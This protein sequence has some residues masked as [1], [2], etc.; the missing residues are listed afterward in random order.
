[1]DL[2]MDR[3][4]FISYSSADEQA[5]NEIC[6]ALESRGLGCWIAARDIPK[7]STWDNE[8]MQLLRDCGAV[9]LVLSERA[10]DSIQVAKEIERADHYEKPILPVRIEP[11]EP[12]GALELH[13]GRRQWTDAWDR[14]VGEVAEELASQLREVLR[15]SDAG[16]GPVLDNL[17]LVDR[18]A[19]RTQL[20]RMAD[21]VIRQ[22]RGCVVALEGPAGVGK[23]RLLEWS[24][25]ELIEPMG[26][27]V[28]WGKHSVFR[29]PWEGLRQIL[30][31]LLEV[32][33][34][35]PEMLRE[36]LVGRQSEWGGVEEEEA[37]VLVQALSPRGG[38]AGEGADAQ[39]ERVLECLM[40]A[41]C[42][43]A[44]R[45]PLAL[46][47]EDIH[48]ADE[49]TLRFI[50][51]AAASLDRAPRP[52]WIAATFR[53]EEVATDES[54]KDALEQLSN[55]TGRTF[56]RICLECLD[57][58]NAQALV[59]EILPG[60]SRVAEELASYGA[61]SPLFIREIVQHLYTQNLI[62]FEANS[63]HL[64]MAPGLLDEVPKTLS[65]LLEGR[66]K[67][68]C[69]LGPW[70][71]MLLACTVALGEEVPLGLLEECLEQLGR[72]PAMDVEEGL[73]ALEDVGLLRTQAHAGQWRVSFPHNLIFKALQKH[74]F[75]SLR[76]REPTRRVHAAAA[77]AKENLYAGQIEQ[78]AAEIGDHYERAGEPERSGRYYRTAARL[79][80]RAFCYEDAAKLHEK[81]GR[82]QRRPAAAVRRAVE[83]VQE[84]PESDWEEAFFDALGC[85]SAVVCGGASAASCWRETLALVKGGVSLEAGSLVSAE[86]EQVMTFVLYIARSRKRPELWD[87]LRT[88]GSALE[89]Q[90]ERARNMFVKAQVL[91]YLGFAG[92]A[93]SQVT[94]V[95]NTGAEFACRAGDAYLEAGPELAADEDAPLRTLEPAAWCYRRGGRF[96][97]AVGCS[98]EF[99]SVLHTCSEPVR[100]L[101]DEVR[102]NCYQNMAEALLLKASEGPDPTSSIRQ[103]IECLR[104]ASGL[105]RDSYERSWFADWLESLVR[106]LRASGECEL[107]IPV[108]DSPADA[109]IVHCHYDSMAADLVRE[110]LEKARLRCVNTGPRDPRSA[111]EM[112][113]A[114]RLVVVMGSTQA[115]GMQRFAHHFRGEP[116]IWRLN[117]FIG[118]PEPFYSYWQKPAARGDGEWISV[119]G[120]SGIDTILA[121]DLFRREYQPLSSR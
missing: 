109:V 57:E 75:G 30:S 17:P 18:H 81:A 119:A 52:L 11:V 10:N 117:S 21:A 100:R 68:A 40:N 61:G 14:P 98:E 113:G 53:T 63:W 54:L 120:T 90:A 45:Q 97:E 13:V 104:S 74:C 35:Q 82:Q 3:R 92:E 65:G 20:E 116:D 41:F 111:G 56:E 114:Y 69:A 88:L 84:A 58:E 106:M 66:I 15:G 89:Q 36:R 37:E 76:Q 51:Y 50:S 32:D 99:M 8:V 19:Y 96:S 27:R 67:R 39:G 93:L 73:A 83:A 107:A 62:T 78:H 108:D 110:R 22:G 115:P 43:W 59:A 29:K 48:W 112:A 101:E 105:R 71:D 95:T 118:S 34:A 28:I 31:H 23:S 46:F 80:M 16:G 2:K 44:R 6:E 94:G 85:C 1:V 38:A 33:E 26:G 4:V 70:M 72:D 86:I 42:Q 77:R 49:Q 60:G 79:A 64:R 24:A 103:A 12:G 87:D 9:V 47:L 25:R 7:G 55:Y 102:S 5:A 91:D 121:A